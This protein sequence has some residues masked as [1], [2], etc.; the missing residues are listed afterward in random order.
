MFRLILMSLKEKQM[1]KL[2]L[3]T[4]LLFWSLNSFSQQG[5][6]I[7]SV[8]SIVPLKAPIA[9]LVIKDLLEGDGNKEELEETNKVLNLTKEKVILKDDVIATL[10]SKVLNLETIIETK[11]EQFDLQQELSDKLVAELKL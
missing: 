1:R 2:I 8:D 5:T 11:Q 6:A 3:L 9:R 7:K 4:S 10:N